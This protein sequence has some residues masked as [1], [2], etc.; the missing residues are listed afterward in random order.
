MPSSHHTIHY[1]LHFHFHPNYLPP[2]LPCPFFS[3]PS[4]PKPHRLPRPRPS[5][6]ET[7]LP[8]RARGRSPR[9]ASAGVRRQPSRRPRP[10]WCYRR[11]RT[12]CRS[13]RRRDGCGR[14]SMGCLRGFKSDVHNSPGGTSLL[15]W[16]GAGRRGGYIGSVGKGGLVGR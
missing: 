5:N 9:F 7:C 3:S 12:R 8:I 10:S 14:R 4:P 2:N 13:H 15:V 6:R 11:Y 16:I 1:H